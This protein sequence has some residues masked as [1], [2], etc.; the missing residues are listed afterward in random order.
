MNA[1]PPSAS[2]LSPAAAQVLGGLPQVN[3]TDLFA[4]LMGMGKQDNTLANLM[5]PGGSIPQLGPIMPKPR[6]P[7]APA[8]ASAPM[9][10]PVA[11][12]PAAANPFM[13]DSA[14]ANSSFSGW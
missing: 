2:G 1:A 10:P 5:M 6:L 8:Q 11:P 14:W 4:T 12:A 13:P 3:W 7:I 9:A